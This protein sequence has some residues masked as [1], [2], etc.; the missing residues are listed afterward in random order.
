MTV[1]SASR[2]DDTLHD[3]GITHTAKS[4]ESQA[5]SSKSASKIDIID[6]R[7]NAVEMNLKGE[8]LS[9]LKPESGPKK[10]P[11]LILYNEQGLQLFEEAR[12]QL[13]ERR[14][15]TWRNTISPTRKSTFWNDLLRI[16]Q[17]LYS[18]SQWLLSWVAL[19]EAGKKVDYYA[20]DLDYAEL[21][22]TLDQVP[23]FEHVKCHGLHGTY[24]D[25]LEWLKTS[26]LS[27]RP[28]F[29]LNGLLNANKI[30]GEQVF[31]LE[32]WDVIGEYV[33]DAEG[34]RHQAFYSPNKDVVFK[35]VIFKAEERI[36]VEQSLKYS[37]EGARQLWENAGLQEIRKWS[38]SSEAY[39]YLYHV[40]GFILLFG[41]ADHAMKV[42]QSAALL[43]S[44]VRGGQGCWC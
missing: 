10:M 42:T 34:G 43:P 20:L 24:D 11:T 39:N 16:L 12:D 30:L 27:S 7:R 29:I 26:E 6:I 35:D 28:K 14:S 37:A 25:G 17:K 8:I 32:D 22:R 38:A 40:P 41:P 19:E 15:H 3:G 1:S 5:G 9:S 36:Q 31:N 21:K 4:V 13:A 2:G 23:A 33:Y 44:N 18:Q